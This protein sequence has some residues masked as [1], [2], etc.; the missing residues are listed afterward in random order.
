MTMNKALV[1]LAIVLVVAMVSA[2]AP[3]GEGWTREEIAQL[4]ALSLR[5]LGPV[6]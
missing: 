2:A 5:E 3:R 6:P 4:T 1:A